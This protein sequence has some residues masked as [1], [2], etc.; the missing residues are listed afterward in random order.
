MKRLLLTHAPFVS[1]LLVG[2]L[3]ACT[4]RTESMDDQ[5]FYEDPGYWTEDAGR[6]CDDINHPRPDRPPDDLPA[7]AV[8]LSTFVM[9]EPRPDGTCDLCPSDSLDADLLDAALTTV[10]MQM[11]LHCSAE[12]TEI[13]DLQRACVSPPEQTEVFGSA[14]C[15]YRARFWFVCHDEP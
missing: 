3:A 15:W 7:D 14:D 12:G 5:C 6:F 4:E 10:E 2:S 1:G 11:S 13:V 9:R 8:S